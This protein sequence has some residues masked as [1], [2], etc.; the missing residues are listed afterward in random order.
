MEKELALTTVVPLLP[1]KASGKVF[2]CYVSSNNRGALKLMHEVT[3]YIFSIFLHPSLRSLPPSLLLR[4]K[5][6]LRR[7]RVQTLLIAT[8]RPGHAATARKQ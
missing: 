8:W 5:L 7:R 4:F 1:P 3:L 6:L 2:H